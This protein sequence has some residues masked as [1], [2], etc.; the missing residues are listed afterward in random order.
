MSSEGMWR[1]FEHDDELTGS[2]AVGARMSAARM[3]TTQV[4]RILGTLEGSA[5]GSTSDL[6]PRL[7]FARAAIAA[8][9]R[10]QAGF[11]EYCPDDGT[12]VLFDRS[13]GEY[14]CAKRH[15]PPGA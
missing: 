7:S 11:S 5:G 13:I 6:A 9:E 3:L 4:E 8:I 12:P 1:P 14:C 15:C 2:D 10:P